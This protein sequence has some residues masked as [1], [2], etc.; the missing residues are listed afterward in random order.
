MAICCYD[1]KHLNKQEL[2]CEY[3]DIDFK[4]EFHVDSLIKLKLFGSICEEFEL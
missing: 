1:C 3:H 4:A 2:I